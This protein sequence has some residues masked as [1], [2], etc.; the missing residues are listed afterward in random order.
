MRAELVIPEKVEENDDDN[1]EENNNLNCV[2]AL[3]D[4]AEYYEMQQL[5]LTQVL[6]GDGASWLSGAVGVV[7]RGEKR[8]QL[9]IRAGKFKENYAN[10]KQ[11]AKER[12]FVKSL[13]FWSNSINAFGEIWLFIS[14]GIVCAQIM[15][16]GDKYSGR[17]YCSCFS[18]TCKALDCPDTS[19]IPDPN[20]ILFSTIIH[21]LLVIGHALLIYF[22]TQNDNDNY[23]DVATTYGKF[24]EIAK[25]MLKAPVDPKNSD[26]TQKSEAQMEMMKK[27]READLEVLPR[28]LSPKPA[29]I[30]FVLVGVFCI[31]LM[32]AGNGLIIKQQMT[33]GLAIAVLG[34]RGVSYIVVMQV[35]Q[36]RAIQFAIA[37][38]CER[39]IKWSFVYTPKLETLRGLMLDLRRMKKLIRISPKMNPARKGIMG[40]WG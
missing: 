7:E 33:A 37:Q 24:H 35:E 11:K 38:L 2:Q 12:E 15:E 14:L 39:M 32:G 9:V 36:T 6:F 3:E 10:A 4:E 19:M 17:E 25:D 29:N 1:D 21:C 27:Q 26:G 8:Q 40:L 18:D 31:G 34:A 20:L 13:T 23:Q 28:V 30:T 22:S 5:S 16:H